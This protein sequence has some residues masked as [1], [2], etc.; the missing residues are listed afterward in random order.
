MLRPLELVN[1]YKF[2]SPL[3][4]FNTRGEYKEVKEFN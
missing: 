4:G 3:F 1:V 2:F